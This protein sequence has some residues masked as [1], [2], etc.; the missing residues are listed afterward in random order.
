[1]PDFFK[2]FC[3]TK[4]VASAGTFMLSFS[5]KRYNKKQ[6]LLGWVFRSKAKLLGHKNIILIYVM[7]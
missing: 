5:L 2:W 3:E 6:L 7:L 4:N 1:M